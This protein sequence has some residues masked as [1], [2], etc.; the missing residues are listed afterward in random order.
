MMT[1]PIA[2]MLTRIR[3]A[4]AVRK[5]QAAIPFSRLKKDILEVLQN[6]GYIE[7]YSVDGE[8]PRKNLLVTLKYVG[9][10]PVV[11]VI[12]RISKP[13][14]RMYAKASDVPVVLNNRGI[15]IL[16]TSQGVMT[17]KAAK[18]LRIGGEILCEVS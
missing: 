17:N 11:K 12:K 10:I 18:Q 6:E 4:S 3:N 2:D 1:D 13:G 15:A 16:S 5:G 9:R 8:G 14:C 7:S